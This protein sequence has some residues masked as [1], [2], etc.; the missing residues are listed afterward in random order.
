MTV[1][2]LAIAKIQK[3]PS[4]LAQEVSDFIDFLMLKQNNQRW[5]QW[6]QF[7]ESLPLAESDFSDYLQNL[8]TYEDQL[9]KGDIQW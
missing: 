7:S 3:L 6:T 8:E 2:D 4:E 9:A 1:Q 5:Q